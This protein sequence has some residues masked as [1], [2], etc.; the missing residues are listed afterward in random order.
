M[1]SKNRS[2]SYKI[3]VFAFIYSGIIIYSP[4][5]A[6]GN[7]AFNFLFSSG[8]AILYTFVLKRLF[9]VATAKKMNSAS[10]VVCLPI[11]FLAIISGFFVIGKYVVALSGFADYYAKPAVVLFAVVSIIA[12]SVLCAKKGKVCVLGFA[13]LVF[14]FFVLWTLCG[15]FAFFTTKH[16]VLPD[17]SFFDIY[18]VIDYAVK[19]SVCICLDITFAWAVLYTGKEEKHVISG[20]LLKGTFWFVLLS[21]INLIKNILLFGKE[22]ALGIDNPDLASLRLVPMF[23]LPEISVVVNTFA[24][25]VKISGYCYVISAVF[26]NAFDKECCQPKE[27]Q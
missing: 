15:F 11:T 26:K 20:S 8:A 13:G 18:G 17:K 14:S 27:A 1:Q 10:R 19:S 5:Y 25:I 2:I 21:G 12:C 6:G 3:Y 22:F 16:V 4:Y 23:D 9:F 7:P 24:C